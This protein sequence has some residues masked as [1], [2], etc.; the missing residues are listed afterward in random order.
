[1]DL[2]ALS[3]PGTKYSPQVS[4][5]KEMDIFSSLLISGLIAFCLMV[6]IVA[7]ARYT[8]ILKCCH[9]EI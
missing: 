1:L 4:T 3:V 9:K 6:L 5:D 2:K 8:P 7:L